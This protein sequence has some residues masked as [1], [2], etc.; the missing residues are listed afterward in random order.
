MMIIGCD[1]HTRY[2]QIVMLDTETARNWS[3]SSTISFLMTE[4]PST[5]D[6]ADCSVTV[7]SNEAQHFPI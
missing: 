7:S 5:G 2:Q 6:V 1:L 4:F 3:G